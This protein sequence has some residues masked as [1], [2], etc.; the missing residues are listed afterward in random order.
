[1][2]SIT[3]RI[4]VFLQKCTSL[5]PPI[6]TEDV[7]PRMK[8]E[9]EATSKSEFPI[10]NYPFQ[11]FL[12]RSS[13]LKLVQMGVSAVTGQQLPMGARFY[14]P[15]SLHNNDAVSKV[16]GRQ[17]MRN[18]EGCASRRCPFKCFHDR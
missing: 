10:S 14:D 1:M 8:K 11:W 18:S 2:A 3:H 9:S 5:L 4:T 13:K 7:R 16:Y 12:I 15:T 6:A 17:A